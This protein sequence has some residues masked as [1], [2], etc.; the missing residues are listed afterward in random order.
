MIMRVRMHVDSPKSKCLGGVYAE[1]FSGRGLL[2]TQYGQL[3]TQYASD[4]FFSDHPPER[5]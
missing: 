2:D 1:F 4:R 3:T 5:N